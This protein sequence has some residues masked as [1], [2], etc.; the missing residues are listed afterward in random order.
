MVSAFGVASKF[1]PRNP[2]SRC[3][4]SSSAEAGYG[5]NLGSQDTVGLLAA[6]LEDSL[7]EGSSY[8]CGFA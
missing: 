2:K 8:V 3:Q 6:V 5:M 4:R 1:L 7:L